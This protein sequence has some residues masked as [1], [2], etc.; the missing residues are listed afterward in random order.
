MPGG[1]F[2]IPPT[3]PG[4]LGGPDYGP[5]M[6]G[7]D[8]PP[9]DDVVLTL[10]RRALPS[11]GA[12]AFRG[13][14]APSSQPDLD[15]RMNASAPTFDPDGF[16]VVWPSATDASAPNR[17]RL[18]VPDVLNE[19]W[20]YLRRMSG[21]V[22]VSQARSSAQTVVMGPPR[23]LTKIVPNRRSFYQ[24]P[25]YGTNENSDYVGAARRKVGR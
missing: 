18:G 14:V 3:S 17:I 7:R 20:R 13:S 19:W 4:G 6:G 10:P 1:P 12:G 22:F 11:L 23:V 16:H 9:N 8:A 2:S 21:Q 5:D 15:P 24:A 25:E